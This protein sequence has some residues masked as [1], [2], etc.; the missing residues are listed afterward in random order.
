MKITGI[1][2][3]KG[4]VVVLD[5][6]G[7]DTTTRGRFRNGSN[8]LGTAISLRRGQIGLGFAPPSR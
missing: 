3:V 6:A 5:E 7:A 8:G 4:F 1:F 2:C